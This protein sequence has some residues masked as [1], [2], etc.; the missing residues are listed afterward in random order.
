MNGGQAPRPGE[1]R[2]AG[3]FDVIG[4]IRE[5][6]KLEAA[7]GILLLVAAVLA[8]VLANS[9]AAH[10]YQGFLSLPASVELGN[11]RIAKPLVL[12]INDGLMAVFFVLVGLEI[13]REV[14]EGQLSNRSQI[15]LPAAAALGGMALPAAIYSAINWGDAHAMRGWAIPTTT[16]IA[17][18]L[19]VLS[20]LGDRVPVGLKVFL[21]TLAILD[22]L[23]AIVIIAL[24]YS[25]EITLPSL[26]VAAVALVALA[27]LN[28]RNVTT[29][30]PYLLVG[31]VLWT[32]VLK[33]GVHATLAGVALA[34]FIPL[35]VPQGVE[36]PLLK[37]ERDLHPAVVFGILPLF[38]FANAGVP[39]PDFSAHALLEP[40]PLGII[41]GLFIGKQ[42]GVF[43]MS[44]LAIKAGLAKL[45]DGASWAMLYGVAL[46]TGIGFTMS[47]FIGSLA[48]QEGGPGYAFNDR[49]GILFGSLA[50][51][52]CGYLVLRR[53]LKQP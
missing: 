7:G 18:A 26:V 34:M 36:A 29:L 38:A 46:L 23:A 11:L 24:F 33:S 35:R 44:W 28:Q 42:L 22:D 16:D 41:A 4:T 3:N 9:P 52:V 19:G 8:L 12:W 47:L 20:L 43:A 25:A 27:V 21:L 53:A 40:V 32:S 50:S 48:F 49:L 51:A 15:I 37:M 1:A 14:L 30:A 6:L 5:F 31:A 45:P 13:K 17:F 2:T 39:L 10:F